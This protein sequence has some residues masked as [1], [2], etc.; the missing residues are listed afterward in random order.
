MPPPPCAVYQAVTTPISP[1][2]ISSHQ[3]IHCQWSPSFIPAGPLTS[4]SCPSYRPSVEKRLDAPI[5]TLSCLQRQ[6]AAGHGCRI[7]V[8]TSICLHT[9]THANE[10]LY[11]THTHTYAF[12][13]MVTLWD[14]FAQPTCS[15]NVASFVSV[16]VQCA[17]AVVSRTVET[18]QFFL[19]NLQFRSC[20]VTM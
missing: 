7:S 11:C 19:F 16:N 12:T 18:A 13:F 3:G 17:S 1:S 6:Q 8:T 9:P 4:S 20:H 15:E 14:V 5:T 10:S 2:F